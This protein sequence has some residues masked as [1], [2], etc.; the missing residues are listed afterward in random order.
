MLDLVAEKDIV[1]LEMSIHTSSTGS[2][3]V[4]VWTRQGSYRGYEKNRNAWHRIAK[5]TVKGKGEGHLTPLPKDAFDPIRIQAG[6]T[7]ALYATLTT[8]EMRYSKG[9]KQGK[10]YVSNDDIS[11][12]EGVGV[13]YPFKS[14]FRPRLWQGEIRYALLDDPGVNEIP[15]PSPT[16]VPAVRSL[17]TT[18]GGGNGQ[19]GNM[20]DI[21]AMNDIDIQGIS[22]IHIN[23]LDMVVVEIYTKAGSYR[24]FER[25]ESAWT[26]IATASV[27]GSGKGERTLLPEDLFDAT[28]VVN[29]GETQGFYVTLTT[30]QMRYTDG[31]EVGAV[32]ASSPDLQI[33]QGAGV[34]YPFRATYQP[35]VWNGGLLYTV[36]EQ[37]NE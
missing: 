22:H 2:V 32:F 21:L 18:M 4:E 28:I 13:S 19:A 31:D 37:G 10:V 35:R 25:D 15:T 7:Q 30:A 6:D 33:L 12:F 26:L 8:A 17:E 24:G 11:I 9:S 14:V 34:V 29:A 16:P 5:T 3:D 1:L 27:K 36:I 23:S 20:Y